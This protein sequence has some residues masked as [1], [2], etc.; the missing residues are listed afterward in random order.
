M[1]YFDFWKFLHITLIAQCRRKVK[2]K[3]SSIYD[4]QWNR[5]SE[6]NGKRARHPRCDLSTSDDDCESCMY[7]PGRCVWQKV[8]NIISFS[9]TR[10]KTRGTKRKGVGQKSA[11]K[12]H[13]HHLYPVAGQCP[14]RGKVSITKRGH[15]PRQWTFE[16][17][18]VWAVQWRTKE[19]SKCLH[20]AHQRCYKYPDVCPMDPD[21]SRI[22]ACLGKRLRNDERK[23]FAARWPGEPIAFIR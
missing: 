1:I 7:L 8:R 4:S 2:K 22:T 3:R 20:V 15:G 10:D 6:E 18:Y 21:G 13:T 11:V 17:T 12:K 9:D 23:R 19:R 5:C 16:E 14:L